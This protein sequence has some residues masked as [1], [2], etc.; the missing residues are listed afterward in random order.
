MPMPV[1]V[2]QIAI[3]SLRV[4]FISRSDLTVEAAIPLT[5][6]AIL[7]MAS[8]SV[9]VRDWRRT[10]PEFDLSEHGP[11]VVLVLG[12][13]GIAVSLAM[14]LDQPDSVPAFVVGAVGATG[15]YLGVFRRLF[16]DEGGSFLEQFVAVT[17][18]LWTAGALTVGAVAGAGAGHY[19]VAAVFGTVLVIATG[20]FMVQRRTGPES[21]M[22][23]SESL[24]G[25]LFASAFLVPATVGTLFGEELL[26]VTY[27]IT[28]VLTVIL[29]WFL[30]LTFN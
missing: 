22:P 14:A 15:C 4:C 16:V 1:P 10:G 28:F 13:I 6:A 29:W 8:L 7:I 26:F 9:A 5:V 17:S 30:R 24:G 12:S 3:R 21:S 25:L 27:S 23:T 2:E 19:A 20:G 18:V 11:A